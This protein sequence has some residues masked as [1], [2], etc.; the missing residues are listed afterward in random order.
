MTGN[1]TAENIRRGL[2]QFVALGCVAASLLLVAWFLRTPITALIYSETAQG[3]D[4]ATMNALHAS[5]SSPLHAILFRLTA[6]GSPIAMW[7][8]CVVGLAWLAPRAKPEVIATWI[9]A[10]GGSSAI[11]TGLKHI[12]LRAR[13]EGAEQYLYSMS[14]SFP[15]T[16]ALASLVGYGMLAYVICQD[17]IPGRT[18]QRLV[19]LFAASIV[20]AIAL[21]RLI[22]GVHYG[23]DVV[24]GLALG[25]FWLSVCIL[26]LRRT[27]RR[28]V[29]A[30]LAQT[31]TS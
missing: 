23:S 19:A 26:L 7:M 15:S 16:H 21:S 24:G 20:T 13:P 12:I 9:A 22:L 5:A 10:F 27:L 28:H 29:T 30:T 18:Q 14:Y 6:I 25:A 3:F 4:V 11:S 2:T 17:R 8:L 31:S 1:H